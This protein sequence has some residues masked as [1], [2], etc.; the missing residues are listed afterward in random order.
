[1]DTSATKSTRICRYWTGVSGSCRDGDKCS[2][3]H[4]A[5]GPPTAPDP[6]VTPCKYWNG[7]PGSCKNSKC[8][9]QHP[10][11]A[12]D[13]DYV[14]KDGDTLSGI[15]VRT[16][17]QKG[18]LKRMN[19]LFQSNHI[20]PG[21]VLRVARQNAGIPERAHPTP[22]PAPK[23]TSISKAERKPDLLASTGEK[24]P[25]EQKKIKKTLAAHSDT[26]KS[27]TF[28]RTR[29]IRS[30]EAPARSHKIKQNDTEI[31]L[32]GLYF[33]SPGKTVK[34]RMCVATL[35]KMLIFEPD[36]EE[37]LVFQEGLKEYSFSIPFGNIQ[38]D[39]VSLKKTEHMLEEELGVEILYR[40]TENWKTKSAPRSRLFIFE[41][42]EAADFCSFLDR[43]TASEKT[44]KLEKSLDLQE[45]SAKAKRKQSLLAS[46]SSSRF[47]DAD[48]PKLKG[49]SKLLTSLK[50]IRELCGFLPQRY[51]LYNWEL[52][53]SSAT[54]GNSYSTFYQKAEYSRDEK[55]LLLIGDSQGYTFGAFVTQ[56]WSSKD[57]YIGT[58][59]AFLF[60][61][62]PTPCCYRSTGSNE[63]YQI[64]S[65]E[66]I[67]F[68]G[69]NRCRYGL[70]LDAAFEKGLSSSSTTYMNKCLASSKE[71]EITQVELWGFI[72]KGTK[73]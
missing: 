10:L 32:K 30:Q 19:K 26:H 11:S 73:D 29:S 45:Q 16:G 13:V 34:G 47:L 4:P 51:Q 56:P 61:F 72:E 39:G 54:D 15:A 65:N 18:D 37:L 46:S 24:K 52:L 67:G 1:M 58:G 66:Y 57:H 43:R 33:I 2:Y 60:S 41:K 64:S 25:E 6:S 9:Y 14:V 63:F 12:S 23:L 49:T 36:M 48:L 62:H 3:A 8:L 50:L 17:N 69:G 55:T 7:T 59:E 42:Q 44:Q 70:W 68:G 35:M 28:A 38:R 22:Q 20:F 21:Q 40:D 31:I 27:K 5:G 71:F 53:F